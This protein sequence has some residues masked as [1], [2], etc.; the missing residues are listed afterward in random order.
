MV[1]RAHSR[2]AGIVA[3]VT[4]ALLTASMVLFQGGPPASNPSSLLNWFAAESW[5]VQGA[6]LLW[7]LAMLALVAFAVGFREAMW[8]TMFDRSWITVLFVQGAAVFATV[9][10]VATAVTWAVTT[11]AAAGTI[12]PQ[13]AA[14]VW[15]VAQTLLLFATWG[16][17]APLLVISLALWRHSGLGRVA[18]CT[19]VLVAAALVVPATWAVGLFAF[20]G[21]MAFVGMTLLVPAP[22]QIRQPA[23]EPSDIS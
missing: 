1:T 11:Q 23:V 3:L 21:W 14:T 19:A 8:A 13:L 4:A 15:G 5:Y 2:S 6:S 9:A 17:T 7:L 20:A 12:E 10:V 22:K 18:A 16:L